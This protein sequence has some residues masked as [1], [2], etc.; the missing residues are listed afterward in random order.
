M[1]KLMKN[2]SDLKLEIQGHTDNTGSRDYNLKLSE[3]RAETV[4]SFLVLYGIDSSRM[5]TKGY[6]PDQPVSSNDTEEGRAQNRRVELK[7]L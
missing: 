1:V 4:K 7:K 5:T 6:G 3:K 2:Y